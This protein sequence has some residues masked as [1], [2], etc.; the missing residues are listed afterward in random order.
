V[1]CEV[2]GLL[3]FESFAD[4]WGPEKIVFV[5]DDRL[6]LNG[7]LVIDNTALGPGKGGIRLAPD[8][9]VNEVFRLARAMTWKN[10]IAGL[11]FGGAKSGIKSNAS[12]PQEKEVLL[13]GFARSL[14]Q[15][16]PDL[17]IAGP[18]MRTGEAEMAAFCS[19]LGT[20][21][22]ATGKPA[23]LGG[24]P[25]ELGSTGFGVAEATEV[26]LASAGQTVSG[27]SVAIEGFGNVGTFTA[28]FLS[29]KGAKIIAVSD[30]KGATFNKNGLE[31][32]ALINWK[33]KEKRD[34]SSFPY[35]TP[36]QIHA[37]F[38][39]EADV[40]IPGARPDA[41]HAGNINDVKARVVV[42][43]ANTPVSENIRGK[44]G[45]AI[46]SERGILVVPDIVANAGGVISSY[47]EHVGGSEKQM[48]EMVREK[49]RSNTKLVLE[50]AEKGSLLARVAAQHIAKERIRSARKP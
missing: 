22:A 45:E 11:P 29:R 5:H 42:E 40:L 26:A 8:V 39:L 47:V 23:A 36:M 18:D 46:L 12:T 24:L 43:A 15:L 1:F 10:A 27:A 34:V 50:T 32:E 44:H 41:L 9:S 37:L 14:K 4:E 25:H 17:Y 21:K 49:I 19:E 2:T 35:G 33:E 31:V 6:R 20:G 16:V 3:Q 13:R 28:H 30:S 48:F 7:V 38:G